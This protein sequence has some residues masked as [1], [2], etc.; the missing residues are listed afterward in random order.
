VVHVEPEAAEEEGALT[1][2]RLCAAR[3]G[4]GAH[5]IRL[6]Q[7]GSGP[8]GHA[9]DVHLEVPAALSV[10]AADA[11]VRRFEDDV[12]AAVPGLSRV[13]VRTEPVAEAG[14]GRA[15][16]ADGAAADAVRAALAAVAGAPE[17]EDL[18]LVSLASGLRVSFRWRVAGD[19]P[20]ST[21]GALAL[22]AERQLRERVPHV[23]RVLVRLTASSR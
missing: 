9:L 11:L 12:R 15:E 23:S 17:P 22:E 18:H 4:L 20:A 2:I 1:R 10:G 19:E 8:E 13:D 5:A 3:Y 21:W 6:F 16:P 14:E 7:L